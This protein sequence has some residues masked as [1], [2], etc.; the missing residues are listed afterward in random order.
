MLCVRETPW[1]LINLD[2][3]RTAAAAGA[4]IM[5]I[6]PPVYLKA[7]APPETVTMHDLLSAFVDR[8]LAVLGH[9]AESNWETIR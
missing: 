6:S 3:A 7:D 2:N 4:V 9:P 1:S 5:P 8:I